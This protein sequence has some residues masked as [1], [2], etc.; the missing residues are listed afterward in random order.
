[1]P[2]SKP[3]YTA[4]SGASLFGATEAIGTRSFSREAYLK[5]KAI[6]DWSNLRF[7]TI[8]CDERQG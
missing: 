8:Y 2:I 5:E 4:W 1:V 7:N 3:I 6:P